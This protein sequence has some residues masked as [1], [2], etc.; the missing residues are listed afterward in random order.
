MSEEDVK[1]YMTGFAE[2]AKALVA[3]PE[4]SQAVLQAS[5]ICDTDGKLTAK[6]Q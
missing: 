1:K 4:K 3:D 5:G 6:Y 2:R